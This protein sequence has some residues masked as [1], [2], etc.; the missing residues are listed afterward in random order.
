MGMYPEAV[1]QEHIKITH[2]EGNLA[3]FRIWRALNAAFVDKRTLKMTF[4]LLSSGNPFGSED[5]SQ[6]YSH[7]REG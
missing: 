5:E 7:M 4:L 2:S 6:S 1:S 3:P